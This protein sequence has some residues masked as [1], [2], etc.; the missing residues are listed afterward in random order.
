MTSRRASDLHL[1][2]VGCTVY[3]YETGY[4]FVIEVSEEGDL[5]EHSFGELYFLG[6]T[7]N[8]L[9][10]HRL[11]GDFVRRRA[12]EHISARLRTTTT[13]RDEHDVSV[14]TGT[15]FTDELPPLLDV[16]RLAE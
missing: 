1:T 6:G 2:Q 13:D 14:C 16:K 9:D 5:P 11:P 15:H 7:S 10:G 3:V 12:S 8:H 4:V